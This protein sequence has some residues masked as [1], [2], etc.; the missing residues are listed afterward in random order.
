MHVQDPS[1]NEGGNGF[2]HSAHG[3]QR[4]HVGVVGG[5]EDLWR[6]Q[7]LLAYFRWP[8]PVLSTSHPAFRILLLPLSDRL[9]L[10]EDC[11]SVG[12]ALREREREGLSLIHI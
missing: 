5:L 8:L 11:V 10:S 9:R 12:S 7:R 1:V 2:I 3:E 4:H 6:Q